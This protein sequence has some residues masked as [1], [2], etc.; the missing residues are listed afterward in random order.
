MFS[1]SPDTPSFQAIFKYY[2]EL[3]SKDISIYEKGTSPLVL[4]VVPEPILASL[5]RNVNFHFQRE[6]M[7]L[8]LNT[9]VTIVGDIH[10]HI[11]DLFRILK[12]FG[13]PPETNYLFLGDIVDRGDFSVETLTLV[14]LLKVIYP[15][16]VW[17]IRGNHEFDEMCQDCGFISELKQLYG[18]TSLKASFLT[19]FSNMPLTAL[20]CEK[21]LCVHGGI[22]PEI[23]TLEEI[24]SIP[25]PLN[26]FE[27]DPVECLVWSDPQLKG[28]GFHPNSR[29]SGCF[30]CQDVFN[31]FI[32]RNKIQAV[33][34]GHECVDTGV[35]MV[36]DRK[37]ITVFSASNYCGQCTNQAGVLTITSDGTKKEVS[38]FKPIR[39]LVRS[40]AKFVESERENTF[41][42]TEETIKKATKRLPRLTVE[43]LSSKPGPNS[44]TKQKRLNPMQSVANIDFRRELLAIQREPGSPPTHKKGVTKQSSTNEL[45]LSVGPVQTGGDLPSPVRRSIDKRRPSF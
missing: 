37:L 13:L 31:K 19:S 32:T 35:Q 5:C 12:Q 38:V 29:G 9:D 25:R 33:V 21:V 2:Q 18:S 22:G 4:P 42:I 27:V 34:R 6:P 45:R 16:H 26:T 23:N 8:R 15:Q 10:G 40:K 36:F 41:V 1:L 28:K 24:D 11:L 44:P 30:F 3:Y 7:M 20:I 14:Y 39:Y 43:N 17:I